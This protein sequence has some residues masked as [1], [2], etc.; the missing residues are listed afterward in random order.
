MDLL[1]PTSKIVGGT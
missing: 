1:P